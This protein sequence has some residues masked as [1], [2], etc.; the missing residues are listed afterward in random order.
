LGVTFSYF[1]T[2]AEAKYIVDQ[3]VALEPVRW[4]N[5]TIPWSELSEKQG[6]GNSGK[7]A[8]TRQVYNNHYSV[9]TKVTSPETLVKVYNTYNE[10]VGAR[11]WYIGNI[12]I[13]RYNTSQAMS[14]PVDQQ[15]VY[16]GR[17]IGTV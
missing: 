7:A 6:F 10:W 9:G 12:A 2:P 1:G 4:Q 5:Q 17:E 13:Q 15:G 11:P 14:V 8:C 3:F 16:P